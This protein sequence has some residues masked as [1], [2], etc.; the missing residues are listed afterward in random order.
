MTRPE[1]QSRIAKAADLYRAGIM[2]LA[3]I[4]EEI[5]RGEWTVRAYLAAAGIELP[6]A[7]RGPRNPRSGATPETLALV[8]RA[9]ALHLEGR[10]YP[11]I[12]REIGKSKGRVGQL[13]ALAGIKPRRGGPVRP[14]R[15]PREKGEPIPP[16][17]SGAT[18]GR[19]RTPAKVEAA[20]RNFQKARMARPSAA[21]IAAMSAVELAERAT[22]ALFEGRPA[23]VLRWLRHIEKRGLT[24]TSKQREAKAE[25]EK[26]LG[27]NS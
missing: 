15:E 26:I 5:G 1:T 25:A 21:D 9:K 16:K 8:E 27:R 17:V 10:A 13:L 14:K 4:G 2:D 23:G 22:L 24:L 11:E 12:A 7:P 18:G 19:V 3:A 20:R 6:K